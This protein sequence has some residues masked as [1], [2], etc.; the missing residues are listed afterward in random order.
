[1]PAG[2]KMGHVHLHVGDIPGAEAVYHAGLGVDEMVWS[3]PGAL[4]RA[5]CGHHHPLGTN[6]WATGAPRAEENDARLL[7]WTVVVPTPADAAAAAQSLE[8]GGYSV[9]ADAE[10]QSWRTTDPWGTPLR[11]AAAKSLS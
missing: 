5:A 8:A 3:Y 7:E 6:T 9:Q 10:R 4:F 1:M 11:I 2:T